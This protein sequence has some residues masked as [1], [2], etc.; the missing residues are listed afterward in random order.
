[1]NNLKIFY[2]FCPGPYLYDDA[3]AHVVVIDVDKESALKQ[4]FD[5]YSGTDEKNW[6]LTEIENTKGLTYLSIRR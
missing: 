4:L 3:V 2:A 6:E 1:M 5:T